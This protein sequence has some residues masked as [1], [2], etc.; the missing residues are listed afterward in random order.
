MSYC[1]SDIIVKLK[2]CTQPYQ[3]RLVMEECIDRSLDSEAVE[4][5]K[6]FGCLICLVEKPSLEI[7]VEAIHSNPSSVRHVFSNSCRFDFDPLASIWLI[8]RLRKFVL[9]VNGSEQIKMHTGFVVFLANLVDYLKRDQVFKD[10]YVSR[11]DNV[12]GED[13]IVEL[14]ENY[15]WHNSFKKHAD[16]FQ[17]LFS[18]GRNKNTC[19]TTDMN[20]FCL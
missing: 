8:A 3:A 4:V 14:I 17:S 12:K 19:A 18:F 10:L 7:I 20:E 2:S 9:S 5:V 11:N 13:F 15:S 6:K 16:D 1:K